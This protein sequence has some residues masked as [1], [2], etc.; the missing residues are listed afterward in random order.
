MKANF[1]FILSVFLL[2]YFL[3]V[4]SCR[5]CN[6]TGLIKQIVTDL[7]WDFVEIENLDSFQ[8][9]ERLIRKSQTKDSVNYEDFALDITAITKMVSSEKKTFN[10]GLIQE[11]YACEPAIPTILES[12]IDLEI[13][14][15]QEYD[16]N[17]PIGSNLADLFEISILDQINQVTN[18][19]FMDLTAFLQNDPKMPFQFTL[20]L[21]SPPAVSK[22][23][24]FKFFILLFGN[25]K[26]ST[27]EIE[28]SKIK[29]LR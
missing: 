14:S 18:S 17:H 29:V 13:T 2:V 27:F 26:P 6:N 16:R 19:G 5:P 28:T 10:F 15:D 24:K 21:K 8:S 25:N 12:I 4:F 23:L 3:G 11:A 22:N 9:G 1:K 20:K 7:T